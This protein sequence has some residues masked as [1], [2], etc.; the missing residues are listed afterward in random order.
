MI[1][2]TELPGTAALL[3]VFL[4]IMVGVMW[5]IE[6]FVSLFTLGFTL[7]EAGSTGVTIVFAILS[8]VAGITLVTSLLGAMSSCGSS[9]KSL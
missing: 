4:V 2:F 3:A 7:G 9:P 1:A 8:I 6:G 5:I